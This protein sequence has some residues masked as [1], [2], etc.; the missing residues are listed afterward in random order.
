MKKLTVFLLFTSIISYAQIDY[1]GLIKNL[2]D[3]TIETDI[4]TYFKGVPFEEDYAGI[5]I[6]DERFLRFYDIIIDKVRFESN[7]GYKTMTLTP[8]DEKADYEKMKAKLIEV[9]GEP[10]TN[11]G[12]SYI[13]YNWKTDKVDISLRVDI[14]DEIF[15]SFDEVTIYFIKEQ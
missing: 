1:T 3:V 12:R 4:K 8:F 13:S 2:E 5:L 14:E 10:E 7:R 9:Y 11:E 15:T 6:N